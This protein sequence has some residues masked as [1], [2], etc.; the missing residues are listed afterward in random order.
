[1]RPA[2]LSR[3]QR[4]EVKT[5]MNTPVMFQYGW[6][7]RLPS[8]FTGE[9]HVVIVKREPSRRSNVEWCEFKERP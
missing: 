3:L 9:K 1:M 2:L 8:D 4:L 7:R 5:E 6:L